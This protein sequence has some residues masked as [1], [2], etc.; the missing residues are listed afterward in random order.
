MSFAFLFNIFNSS[1]FV[2]QTGKL[3]GRVV[4]IEILF[5]LMQFSLIFG[6]CL[7]QFLLRLLD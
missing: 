6:T 5:M 4:L 7:P 2:N 1:G 3:I